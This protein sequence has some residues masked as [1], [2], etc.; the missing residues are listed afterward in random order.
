MQGCAIC[1]NST[2][3]PKPDKYVHEQRH[4]SYKQ[5]V[6]IQYFVTVLKAKQ[7]IKTL[8]HA[9]IHFTFLKMLEAEV[10]HTQDVTYV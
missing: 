9:Y 6:T 2:K 1:F 3:I 5:K 10:W 8:V 4:I 7:I